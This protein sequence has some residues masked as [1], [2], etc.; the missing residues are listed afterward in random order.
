MGSIS[1]RQY[2]SRKWLTKGIPCFLLFS[3]PPQWFLFL[4]NAGLQHTV[5]F[6]L[7]LPGINQFKARLKLTLPKRSKLHWCLHV[8]LVA[9]TIGQSYKRSATVIYDTTYLESYFTSCD[10]RVIITTNLPRT[11]ASFALFLKIILFSTFV[12][13]NNFHKQHKCNNRLTN[14]SINNCSFCFLFTPFF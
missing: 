8:L 9:F 3:E 13:F 10:S 7:Y 5:V 2:Q 4:Q 14:N 11:P 12:I 6:Q 1:I